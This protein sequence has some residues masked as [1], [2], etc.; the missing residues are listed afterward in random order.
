MAINAPPNHHAGPSCHQEQ[1][2]NSTMPAMLPAM[3][4]VYA[5]TRFEMRASERPSCWPGPAITSVIMMKSSPTTTSIGT[6]NRD[7]SVDWYSAPKKTSCVDAWL[8]KSSTLL[9]RWRSHS[10]QE[11][12]AS[13]ITRRSGVHARTFRRRPAAR[14]PTDMPRK[15]ASRTVLVKNDRKRT[16]AGKPA[17]ARELEKQDQHADEKQVE[18]VAH[19]QYAIPTRQLRPSSARAEARIAPGLDD[20]VR[21]LVDGALHGA[22]SRHR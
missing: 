2:V 18:T 14:Q 13:A 8:P 11:A 7:G 9:V 10:T 1:A 5:S 3:L 16:C 15:Q 12:A 19:G 22:V 21:P 6:T 20:D 17:D 4:T